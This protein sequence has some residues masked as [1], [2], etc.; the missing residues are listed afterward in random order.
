MFNGI[1]ILFIIFLGQ[2]FVESVKYPI[3]IPL[4]DE[5]SQKECDMRRWS[6]NESFVCVCNS[7]HCDQPEPLGQLRPGRA[8]L[9]MSDPVKM[10]LKRTELQRGEQNTARD[11]EGIKENIFYNNFSRPYPNISNSC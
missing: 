6:K 11:K 7:T 3:E 4:V 5:G 10:R 9:F 2:T 8:V 1:L